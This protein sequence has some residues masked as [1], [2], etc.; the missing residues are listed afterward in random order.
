MRSGG[1]DIAE[2]FGFQPDDSSRIAIR[3]WEQKRCP[4]HGNTCTKTNH[5]GTVIYGV[6]SVREGRSAAAR[7]VVVCPTRLY[8]D[9][10]A[11]LQSVV[12]AVWGNAA[13]LV[14]SGSLQDLRARA[15]RADQPVVAFGHGSGHEISLQANGSV[16]LDWVLQSYRNRNGLLIP[17]SFVGVEVQSIDTT[18]NYRACVESYG[19]QK[20]GHKLTHVA[21]SSHGLNFANVH[22]RLI[23]QIIRKGNIY[24]RVNS[25]A[26]FV[27]VVPAAVYERFDETLSHPAE[28]GTFSRVS[29]SV[30]PC[31][32]GP[33][34]G[35]GDIRHLQQSAFRHFLLED[36][37]HAFAHDTEGNAPEQLEAILRS[38]L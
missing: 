17:D 32:L 5:D 33:E 13:T 6:C 26:G 22:K 27:F 19:R 31:N 10:Y 20:A 21:A 9:G 28:V 15:L 4:F 23:P 1:N 11:V 14:V 29:V 30:L 38:I 35:F 25:C 24:S 8:S 34:R 7:D 2:L 18:G 36:I 3:H 12:S 37:K 16:A